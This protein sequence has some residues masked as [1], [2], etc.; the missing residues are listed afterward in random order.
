MEDD[1]SNYA[2]EIKQLHEMTHVV[3]VATGFFYFL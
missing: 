2:D 3:T 1:T